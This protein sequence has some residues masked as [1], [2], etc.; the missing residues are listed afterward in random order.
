MLSEI[1]EGPV[2]KEGVGRT[3]AYDLKIL[4]RAPEKLYRGEPVW[5]IS[6][7]RGWSYVIGCREQ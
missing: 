6:R 7:P 5:R 2:S 4:P 1:E 3:P